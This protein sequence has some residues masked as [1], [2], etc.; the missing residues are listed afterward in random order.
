MRQ[1]PPVSTLPT[2]WGVEARRRQ[3]F[4]EATD[5]EWND[6][7]WQ[8]RRAVTSLDAVLAY[9]KLPES[10]RAVLAR[11]IQK[12][13]VI[14][15]PYYLC[16]ID[17]ENSADPIR[18]QS[19]PARE[20]IEKGN[21]GEPDPLEE[22]EDMGVPGLV[23]RY[24]DRVLMQVT[25]LCPMN[26]RHC[27][28]KR[29]WEEGIWMRSDQEIDRMVDY[30]ARTPKV[31]DVLI[32]GGDPLVLSTA[33][34]E[35]ILA[36][37]RTLPHLEILRIGTR[38]P[39]VLPQRI[40]TGLVEMLSKYRPL[41][42]NTHFNHPREITREAARACDRLQRAGIPMNN[43]S[44]LLRGVNDSVSVMKELCHGLLKIGVRPYYLYQCDPVKGAEHLRTSLWKGV[45]IIEGLRGHT[46]GFAVPQFVI[47]TPGGGGKI[48]VGPNYL[49]SVTEDGVILRN[50]EGLIF[51]YKDPVREGRTAETD[52]RHRS[53][54]LSERL[55]R[56]RAN[57][58]RPR[59]NGRY[60]GQRHWSNGPAKFS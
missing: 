11:V 43:Q 57:Y 1:A 48:P 46:T 30:L 47:D 26:C 24:P 31:R 2:E 22:E 14:I 16:L 4:G 27:T 10:E 55:A 5:A 39:V 54:H 42:V 17:F 6:W 53:F 49:V 28:R 50:Y 21:W 25:N 59:G 8:L 19:F 44:V 36:K 40:D 13:P 34:L 60:H 7:R 29:E 45:E 12:Y 15:P 56:R 58:G 38:F 41:W 9:G 35:N 18:L 20:E 33:R 37:L 51:E 3:L 23:H 32:S 52:I